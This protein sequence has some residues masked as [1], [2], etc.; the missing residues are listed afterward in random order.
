MKMIEKYSQIIDKKKI[1]KSSQNS[2]ENQKI[3]PKFSSI[4]KVY[5]CQIFKFGE[6]LKFLP[7]KVYTNAVFLIFV[8]FAKLHTLEIALFSATWGS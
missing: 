8:A 2:H 6:S 3:W 1:Q 7:A 4:A 5:T